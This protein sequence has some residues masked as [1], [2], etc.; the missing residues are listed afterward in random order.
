M[1]D[2]KVKVESPPLMWMER[3]MSGWQTNNFFG[4]FR[5]HLFLI[6]GTMMQSHKSLSVLIVLGC[7]KTNLM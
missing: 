3:K 1:A 2:V 5:D 4:F 6:L 7:H